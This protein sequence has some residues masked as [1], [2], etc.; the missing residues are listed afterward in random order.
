MPEIQSGC[1]IR[2]IVG[3]ECNPLRLRTFLF[4]LRSN[5]FFFRITPQPISRSM[6]MLCDSLRMA[7]RSRGAGLYHFLLCVIFPVVQENGFVIGG[8][9]GIV[10]DYPRIA[11]AQDPFAG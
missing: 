5:K 1:P 11:I 9:S 6:P 10:N 4:N 3:H 8:G 7:G 2:S